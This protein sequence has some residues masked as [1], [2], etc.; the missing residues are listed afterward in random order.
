MS[1]VV[2]AVCLIEPLYINTMNTN[3]ISLCP[4]QFVIINLSFVNSVRTISTA[5][6]IDFLGHRGILLASWNSLVWFVTGLIFSIAGPWFRERYFKQ[7]RRN[8]IIRNFIKCIPQWRWASPSAVLSRRSIFNCITIHNSIILLFDV[9]QKT[10]WW[11]FPIYCCT[12]RQIERHPGRTEETSFEMCGALYGEDACLWV[13]IIRKH[14]KNKENLQRRMHLLYEK[15]LPYTC[16]NSYFCQKCNEGMFI[17]NQIQCGDVYFWIIHWMKCDCFLPLFGTWLTWTKGCLFIS[18]KKFTLWKL[19]ASQ[20]CFCMS[21]VILTGFWFKG[22]VFV[23]FGLVGWGLWPRVAKK[24]LR[25]TEKWK[26]WESTG[27]V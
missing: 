17:Y 5:D 19:S 3:E 15:I 18:E 8:W 1:E 2:H 7:V 16:T 22:K 11:G 9:L 25:E 14:E 13:W 21:V 10:Q 23:L 27:W 6:C 4:N 12:L 24:L 26:S 20:M